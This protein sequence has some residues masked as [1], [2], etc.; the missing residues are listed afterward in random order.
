MVL[1]WAPSITASSLLASLSEASTGLSSKAFPAVADEEPP[2]EAMR[3]IRF[4]LG[5]VADLAELIASDFERCLAAQPARI[6]GAILCM[7][8][9][10]N[11]RALASDTTGDVRR[12]AEQRLREHVQWARSATTTVDSVA[13]RSQHTKHGISLPA[14]ETIVAEFDALARALRQ[15]STEPAFAKKWAG[16]TSSTVLMK[17]VFTL[18]KFFDV[19]P[20]YLKLFQHCALKGVPEAVV[21]GMGSVWDRCATPGRHLNF[22]AGAQEAVVCWNA[23]SPFGTC[24]HY[25]DH[26]LNLHFGGSKSLRFTRSSG[27]IAK[28][29][30]QSKALQKVKSRAD[31][32]KMPDRVWSRD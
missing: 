6:Q 31:G 14:D 7:R 4:A 29:A 23:P 2:A 5:G 16:A 15:A 9:C 27:S 1:T 26:A 19:A 8:K 13:G 10:L 11:L 22:E 25:L 24:A 28:R 32:A 3:A 30:E 21:E 20:S 12:D 17:D 18:P